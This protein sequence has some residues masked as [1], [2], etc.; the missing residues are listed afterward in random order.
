M[1]SASIP[2]FGRRVVITR[3]ASSVA[4][5][6]VT[7]VRYWMYAGSRV[8]RIRS[9]VKATSRAVSG[10]PSCHFMPSLIWNVHVRPS[11]EVSQLVAMSGAGRYSA[12]YQVRKS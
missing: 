12:S 1:A 11:S 2:E 5:T 3:V 8:S 7:P 10:T 6:A 9:Y 4:E